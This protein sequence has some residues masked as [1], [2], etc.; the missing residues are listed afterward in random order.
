MYVRSF[1]LILHKYFFLLL[2]LL[3]SLF[4]FLFYPFFFTYFFI[5]FFF[6]IRT[7]FR[8]YPDLSKEYK[9]F[10]EAIAPCCT[11]HPSLVMHQVR[12]LCQIYKLKKPEKQRQ[13]SRIQNIIINKGTCRLC[14]FHS[15]LK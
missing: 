5:I 15:F 4:F 12:T 9:L 8:L 13:A 7:F 6:F 2:F 14:H 10:G 11:P 3:F 1:E